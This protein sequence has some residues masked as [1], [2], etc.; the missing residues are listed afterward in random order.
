MRKERGTEK[1]VNVNMK[2]VRKELL[3]KKVKQRRQYRLGI[4]QFPSTTRR[5][6]QPFN[7]NNADDD[8]VKERELS[9]IHL[10]MKRVE[11]ELWQ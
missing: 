10:G 5:N 7:N 8:D 3:W 6:K 11:R 4:A 1:C 2:R 9:H